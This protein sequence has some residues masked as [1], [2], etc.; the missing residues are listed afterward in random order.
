MANKGTT[1]RGYENRNGQVNL[2]RTDPVRSG[3]GSNQYVYVLHCPC[4]GRN[5]GS[6]GAD[7]FQRKCPSCQGGKAGEPLVGDEY[8]WR[9]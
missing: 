2:G 9:P 7:I 5:Y 6:N 3:S 4:C 8:D 1:V